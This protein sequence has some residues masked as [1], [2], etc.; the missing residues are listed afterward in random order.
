MQ[1]VKYKVIRANDPE[2]LEVLVQ[3]AI[4]NGFTPYGSPF[5]FTSNENHVVMAGGQYL[6]Q[7]AYQIYHQICQAVVKYD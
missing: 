1:I 2:G 4:D 7:N 6:T 5:L 3:D